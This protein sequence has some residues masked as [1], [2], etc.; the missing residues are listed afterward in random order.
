MSLPLSG[1]T[2][3]KVIIYPALF[4][5]PF[6]PGAAETITPDKWFAPLADPVRIRPALATGSQPVFFFQP[7]P[8]IKIDWFQWM[9]EPVRFRNL[10]ARHQ[11][12][13][14]FQP[15]PIISIEWWAPFGE[16]VRLPRRLTTG[17]QRSEFLHPFPIIQISWWQPLAEPIRPRP[18]GISSTLQH[19]FEFYPFPVVTVSWWQPFAEPVRPRPS[20]IATSLQEVP[21]RFTRLVRETNRRPLFLAVNTTGTTGSYWKGRS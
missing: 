2:F 7:T 15:F 8:I 13:F 14:Q 4:L 12:W 19:F 6:I 11:Q 10:P 9:A 1:P 5:T 20:G 21:S 18:K 16:P 17:N 3:T